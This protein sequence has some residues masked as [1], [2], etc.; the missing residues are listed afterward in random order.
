MKSISFIVLFLLFF[1]NL[2]M[3]QNVLALNKVSTADQDEEYVILN[4][5]G[6]V[7]KVLSGVDI[8]LHAENMICAYEDKTRK[9]TL[10]I[11]TN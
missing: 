3:T 2:G 9:N 7:I 11:K 10:E 8:K 4:P 1:A 5:V 6:K